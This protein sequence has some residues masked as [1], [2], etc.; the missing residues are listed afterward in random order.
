[1]Y[2]AHAIYGTLWM[3][4]VALFIKCFE[5][6]VKLLRHTPASTGLISPLTPPVKSCMK[7]CC[8]LSRKVEGLELNKTQICLCVNNALLES[9]HIFVFY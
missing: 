3:L 9:C 5:L 2:T 8:L 7:N 1:M 4:Y 6:F